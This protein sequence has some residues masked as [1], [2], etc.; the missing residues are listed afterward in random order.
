MSERFSQTYALGRLLGEGAFGFVMTATRLRDNMQ[1]AV[2]FINTD[3]IPR[4]AWLPDPS[5]P[6]GE[7]VPPEIAILQQIRHPYVIQ[8]IDHLVECKPYALLITELH[9][10]QWALPQSSVGS[11]SSSSTVLGDESTPFDLCECI[12]QHL[13]E[14]VARKVFA[15]V[16]LAV[17]HLQTQGIVHR[18]IK[19]DNI[20][21]DSNFAVKIIDFGC[22]AWIPKSQLFT[23]FCGTIPFA[24]PEMLRNEAYRGPEV[25]I[26]ALGVLLYTMVF[27]ELPFLSEAET[28]EGHLIWPD[29]FCL[30]SDNDYLKSKSIILNQ[31][32][33]EAGN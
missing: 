10:S 23:Q 14:P 15:Q 21:V 30:D 18:D 26:W 20:V 25:E 9:G 16:L 17:K 24:S 3:F 19:H 8:Y 32:K 31:P 29:G 13:A 7:R 33:Y 27:G 11:S 5:S 2:K 1:V 22:A 28:I 4:S 6:H 12:K